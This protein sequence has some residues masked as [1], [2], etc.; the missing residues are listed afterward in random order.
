MAGVSRKF[1]QTS[2][3]KGYK[4]GVGWQYIM[5]SCTWIPDI[6][7]FPVYSHAVEFRSQTD[8]QNLQLLLQYLSS[9]DFVSAEKTHIDSYEL[10]AF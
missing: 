7:L 2:L 3:C 1:A 5:Q 8:G 9:K 6:W 4:N 10:P